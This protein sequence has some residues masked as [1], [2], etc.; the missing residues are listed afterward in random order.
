[1]KPPGVKIFKTLYKIG[2][3]RL[4]G[5]LILILTTTGRKS[6]LPRETALQYEEIDGKIYIGSSRGIRSDWFKN[7]LVDPRVWVRVKG[8]Y[9]QGLAEPVVDSQRIADF[10]VLRL[11]RHPRMVGEILK[12]EGLPVKPDRDRLEQYAQNLAMVIIHPVDEA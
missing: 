5:R 4:V 7:I 9:F 10:L 8:S 1:M 6:G 12:S 11:Q 3:G 2:L